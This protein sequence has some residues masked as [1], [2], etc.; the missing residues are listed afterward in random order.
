MSQSWEIKPLRRPELGVYLGSLG[1]S[2]Q[3]LTA[4]VRGGWEHDSGTAQWCEVVFMRGPIA[5]GPYTETPLSVGEVLT[6][7]PHEYHEWVA[8][9]TRE[10]LHTFRWLMATA[11]DNESRSLVQHS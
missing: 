1:T 3:T 6:K 2:G 11:S 4:Y 8:E 10:A 7:V 5:D 9:E